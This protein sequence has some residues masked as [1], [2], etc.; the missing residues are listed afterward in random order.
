MVVVHATKGEENAVDQFI[1][2][3]RDKITEGLVCV[4]AAG[5]SHLNLKRRFSC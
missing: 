3:H 1:T 4:L 5:Q 2:K